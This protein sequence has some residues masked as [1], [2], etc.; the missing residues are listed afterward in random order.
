MPKSDKIAISLPSDLLKEIERQCVARGES[1]SQFLRMAVEEF[2]RRERQR[3]L[4]KQYVQGY[5]EMPETEEE[6]AFAQTLAQIA[7]TA[8]PWEG[9]KEQ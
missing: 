2:L 4:E 5:Q 1:R 6:V 3:E 9:D 8:N 7:F